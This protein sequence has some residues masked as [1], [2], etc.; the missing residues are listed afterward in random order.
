MMASPCQPVKR[1]NSSRRQAIR[2]SLPQVCVT[3]GATQNLTLDHIV[4]RS[5]GGSNER[6]NLQILCKGCNRRKAQFE[7]EEL[8]KRERLERKQQQAEYFREQA[9]QKRTLATG[10]A[11]YYSNK[12]FLKP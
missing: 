2:N 5:L 10:Q 7:A 3:C 6:H 1:L 8:Q 12:K 11:G 9:R 4:A